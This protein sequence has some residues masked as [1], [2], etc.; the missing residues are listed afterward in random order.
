MQSSSLHRNGAK[1]VTAIAEKKPKKNKVKVRE[2]SSTSE[3][4]SA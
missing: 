2:L 1:E 3:D 4:A